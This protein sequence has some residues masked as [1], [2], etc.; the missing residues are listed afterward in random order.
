VTGEEQDRNDKTVCAHKK[1]ALERIKGR[2]FSESSPLGSGE[3]LNTELRRVF[4]NYDDRP[5]K[6]V[7]QDLMF[8][9][10]ELKKTGEGDSGA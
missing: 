5:I 3:A 7:G 9:A 4:K 2:V 8:D 6:T 1:Y 10:K